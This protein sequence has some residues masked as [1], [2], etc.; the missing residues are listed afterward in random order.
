MITPNYTLVEEEF[1]KLPILRVKYPVHAE[2]LESH[3][4][5]FL[6]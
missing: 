6:N 1:H 3:L 5:L 2:K 4:L